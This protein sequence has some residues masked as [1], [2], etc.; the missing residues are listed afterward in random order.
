MAPLALIA[1]PEAYEEFKKTVLVLV[2]EEDSLVC[3]A[4]SLWSTKA[5][6][7][8]ATMLSRTIRQAAGKRIECL[9]AAAHAEC[10]A[11]GTSTI[12]GMLQSH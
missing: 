4:S 8:T 1:Y 7:S 3:A 6:R 10:S 11:H 12:Q 9:R 2:E 5:S